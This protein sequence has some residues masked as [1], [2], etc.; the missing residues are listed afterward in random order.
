MTYKNKFT[1]GIYAGQLISDVL[2][3]DK[4]YIKYCLQNKLINFPLK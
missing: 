4:D 2:L 3:K 1:T